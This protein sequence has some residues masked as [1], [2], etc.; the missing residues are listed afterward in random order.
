M[1][2][3]RI[4]A[5]IA[6]LAAA[7]AACGTRATDSPA[8]ASGYVEAT[9]VRVASRIG[10]RIAAVN[11]QEGQRVE[12]GAVVATLS[13]VDIDL[14]LARIR[15][16]RAQAVAQLNLLLAGP[17]PEDIRLCRGA[18]RRRECR[19]ACGRNRPCVRPHRRGPLP[20]TDGPQRRRRQTARRCRC[21][22]AV[23]GSA[24]SRGRGAAVGGEVHRRADQGR[25]EA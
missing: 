12:A 3:H 17:R 10:G 2:S 16:E 23:G 4:T 19:P 15:T 5:G 24:G 7:A 1:S 22:Q 11:V 21:A 8:R 13:P 25:R 18:G 14:A 20:A 9:D 6:L